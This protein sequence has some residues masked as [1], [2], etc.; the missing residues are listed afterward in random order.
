MSA[1]CPKNQKCEKLNQKATAGK[2]ICVIFFATPPFSFNIKENG[3]W[4]VHFFCTFPDGTKH[5]NP[6]LK[7][8]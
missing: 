3:T 7:E 6:I 2:S 5:K 1:F 4:S 8:N